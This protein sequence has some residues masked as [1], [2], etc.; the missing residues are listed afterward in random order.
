MKLI[1]IARYLCNRT[2]EVTETER[3]LVFHYWLLTDLFFAIAGA[4]FSSSGGVKSSGAEFWQSN[5]YRLYYERINHFIE[6]RSRA[7][8]DNLPVAAAWNARNFISVVTIL[9][10]NL[11][12]DI[13]CNHRYRYRITICRMTI[14]M[15]ATGNHAC[16]MMWAHVLGHPPLCCS[17]LLDFLSSCV[18]LF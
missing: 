15:V 11:D 10:N 18:Q 7:C 4:W 6:R 14:S 12:N 9:C 16:Q 17:N 13:G 8:V 1:P 5:E 2:L 3:R